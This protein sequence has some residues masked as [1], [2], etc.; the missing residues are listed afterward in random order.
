MP[1][2]FRSGVVRPGRP[3]GAYSTATLQRQISASPDPVGS[4]WSGKVRPGIAPCEETNH[5]IP[6][7]DCT[8]NPEA[9]RDGLLTEEVAD[10]LVVYDQDTNLAHR[11]NRSSALVW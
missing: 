3:H 5:P 4:G 8:M 2:L 11:L 6:T 1:R 10:E 9:R 7:G